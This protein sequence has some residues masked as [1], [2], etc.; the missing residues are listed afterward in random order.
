MEIAE[1]SLIEQYVIDVVREKRK[2]KSMSQRDLADEMELS[3]GF[4]AATEST[5]ERAKY[6]L[7][8]IN[9]LAKIFECSP[10]DFLPQDV[11]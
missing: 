6:N 7:A 8:H 9:T 3:Y 5:K 11:L 4:I 1:I 2:E 10:K